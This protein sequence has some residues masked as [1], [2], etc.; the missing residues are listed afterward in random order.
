MLTSSREPAWGDAHPMWEVAERLVDHGH[1]DIKTR[2]PDDIPLGRDNKIYGIAPIGPALMH[3]PGA[4]SA[5]VDTSLRADAGRRWCGH[6]RRTSRHRR[7]VRSPRCCS[8]C[9]SA[10]WE[11]GDAP[12]ARARRS[13]CSRRRRGCTRTIR[14]ARSSSSRRSL[15]L[16]RAT[17]RVANDPTKREALWWGAWAG[18]AVQQ[19]VRVRARGRR[20]GDR[21]SAGRCA[22]VAKI[23]S[24]SRHGPRSAARRS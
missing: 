11:S 20:R 16:F 24:A 13:S 5:A 8:S 15:G 1:I 6:S 4:A 10:I 7:W 14:I 21:R 9:C 19:Q 22:R 17:L 12:R 23:S 2:W 18:M 3:V